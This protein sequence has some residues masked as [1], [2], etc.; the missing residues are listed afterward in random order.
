MKPLG[1]A[2]L[3]ATLLAGGG[4][5]AADDFTRIYAEGTELAQKQDWSGAADRFRRALAIKATP[6][7]YFNLAQAEQHLKR[8]L[9]AKQHFERARDEAQRAGSRDLAQLAG[10]ALAAVTASIPR[11]VLQI[12][13]DAED[14]KI[15]LD[16]RRVARDPSGIPVN[17][18]RH[19]IT[20]L[21]ARQPPFERAL[22]LDAG[23]RVE[24]PIALVRTPEVAE[25]TP[26]EPDVPLVT[27]PTAET[28]SAGGPP[29]G[30]IILGAV[31]VGALGGAGYFALRRGSKLDEAAEIAGCT[32]TDSG[33][34][35]PPGKERDPAHLALK[36]EADSAASTAN[37]LAG[38]GAGALL[39]GAVWWLLAPGSKSSQ[40]AWLSVDLRSRR[41]GAAAWWAF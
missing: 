1:A 31:G 5:A 7:V 17:P 33:F 16:G 30:A 34:A 19:R 8:L 36:D 9:E 15:G 40:Q 37:V 14:V 41:I 32:R 26:A 35:C 24:V 23:D 2:L 3:L 6:T 39:A 29:A 10:E 27:A 11:I 20:V 18:G 4:V 13:A 28:P 22:T 21:A 38:V 12:P 25:P